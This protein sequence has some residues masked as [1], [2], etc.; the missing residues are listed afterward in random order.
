MPEEFSAA[1]YPNPVTSS[2][3]LRYTF[4]SNIKVNLTLRDELGRIV[5]PPIQNVNENQLS[6]DCSSLPSGAYYY[7]LQVGAKVI[8]GKMVVS[9]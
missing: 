2:A 6:I 8:R 9:H 1:I 5:T 3:T 7:S 4:A